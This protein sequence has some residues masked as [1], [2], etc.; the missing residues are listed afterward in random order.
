MINNLYPSD[1][2]FC[3]VCS[4]VAI[5]GHLV[6]FQLISHPTSASTKT[7]KQS[8]QSRVGKIGPSCLPRLPIR[9]KDS[10]HI[11]HRH[12]QRYNRCTYCC[13]LTSLHLTSL[14]SFT[15]ILYNYRIVGICIHT[16]PFILKVVVFQ[17]LCKQIWKF[18][19]KKQ[20]QNK[21][22]KVI[23]STKVCSEHFEDEDC[24]SVVDSQTRRLKDGS[25][26]HDLPLFLW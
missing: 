9:T 12:C 19:G 4:L 26:L 20:D 5:S 16:P 25:V 24:K 6:A 17:F 3:Y 21:D 18:L 15:A 13:L 23:S 7:K 8:G 14:C 11:A 10:L 1:S 2:V 22:S